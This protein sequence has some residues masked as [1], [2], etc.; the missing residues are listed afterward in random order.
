M[1]P[2][3]DIDVVVTLAK[4]GTT[5]LQCMDRPMSFHTM[6]ALIRREFQTSMYNEIKARTKEK[7]W[8]VALSDIPGW[9]RV[10]AVAEFRLRT[11]H[12]GLA[13]LL[14]RL[15]LY[16]QPTCPLCNLHEEMVVYTQPTCPLCNLHEEMEKTHLIRCLALKP[17]TESQ[18][19]SE[20][21]RLLMNGY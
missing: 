4:K 8:T 5:I 1:N 17:T 11:G 14:H 9:P 21:R 15:R 6:E 7:Q 10:E 19:Y 16:T 13:K 2:L 20:A 12:D 3:A 18:K